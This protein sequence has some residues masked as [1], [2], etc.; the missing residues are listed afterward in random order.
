M[1]GVTCGLQATWKP[2]GVGNVFNCTGSSNFFKGFCRTSPPPTPIKGN[3]LTNIEISQRNI[4]GKTY[5]RC[6]MRSEHTLDTKSSSITS[7]NIFIYG[8]TYS[9]TVYRMYTIDRLPNPV[10][11]PSTPPWP[12]G[13]SHLPSQLSLLSSLRSMRSFPSGGRATGGDPVLL[14]AHPCLA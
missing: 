9:T 12:C 5:R 13:Q 4:D 3:F 2:R 1:P 10:V 11:Q 6:S 14:L 8:G 7:K